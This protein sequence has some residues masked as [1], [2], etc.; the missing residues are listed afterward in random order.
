MDRANS[1]TGNT[2]AATNHIMVS[3]DRDTWNQA[4]YLSGSAVNRSRA[5]K[6]AAPPC[7]VWS[8][9]SWRSKIIHINNTI[10]DAEVWISEYKACDRYCIYTYGVSNRINSIVSSAADNSYAI[11]VI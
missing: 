6:V 11:V 10:F 4:G 5:F 7:I 2:C 9:R 8:N 3:Q 1:I